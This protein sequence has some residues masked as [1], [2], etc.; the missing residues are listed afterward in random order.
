MQFFDCNCCYGLSGRP[1]YRYAPDAAALLTELDWCGIARALVY[2]AGMRFDSPL[3]WNAQLCDDLRGQPRLA[4][5]W[6]ILP[7]QTGEFPP[8]E[9]VPAILQ[10]EGVRALRAFP[11]E[12]RYVLD[13]LTFGPLLDVLAAHRIP[14]FVKQNIVDIGRLLAECPGLIVVAMNVGP[15]SL[16]RYVRPLLDA[17]PTLY[18]ET[19]H[20]LSAGLIEGH[21]DRYGAGRLLFGSGY[22]DVA[23]GAALLRLAH[24]EIDDGAKAAIAGGNLARL[25]EEVRR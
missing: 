3:V 19:S 12:H 15:H 7:A 20:Y 13:R 8:A 23:A 6:A 11:D 5:S 1:P 17:F 22:P 18:L 25:L 21:V 2:H 4:A 16:E 14:L 10:A 9:A 24:A